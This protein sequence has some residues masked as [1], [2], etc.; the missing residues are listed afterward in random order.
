MI[1]TFVVD[2]NYFSA[3]GLRAFLASVPDFEVGDVATSGQEALAHM[4]PSDVVVVG[5]PL[6]DMP[7]AQFMDAIAARGWPT[8]MLVIGAEEELEQVL[9]LLRAGAHGYFLRGD[10]KEN[11]EAAIRA[12][13]RREPW[14]SAQ[15]MAQLLARQNSKEE[16]E[17]KLTPRQLEVLQLVGRGMSNKMIALILHCELRTVKSHLE[18]IFERLGVSSRTEAY[19]VARDRGWLE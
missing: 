1:K 9:P 13:E 12:V 3:T 14:F 5:H 4:S 6:P 18:H 11:M 17:K 10:S 8:R 15:I 7:L 16:E 2:G 19:R